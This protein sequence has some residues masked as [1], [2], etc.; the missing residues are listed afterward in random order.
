MRLLV[1]GAT[2]FVGRNVVR[3]A[4]DGGHQ[5]RALVRDPTRAASTFGDWPVE[6]VVG[7]LL[8]G[9]GLRPALE[10]IDV[11]V[12]SAATYSYRRVDSSVML[13]D[14]RVI[15][16]TLLSAAAEAG[17]AHV[18]DISSGIALRP[19]RSGSRAGITDAVSPNW[20]AA[21]PQWRDP[22]LRSKVE[23]DQVARRFAAAGL[24]VTSIHPSNVIGPGD[25]GPGT[26]GQALVTLLASPAMAVEA[27]SNWVDVRDLAG[28]IVA[29]A[30]RPP[31]GRYLLSGGYF[32]FREMA[33]VIDAVTGRRPRRLWTSAR[34]TR[35]GASTN[36]LFDGRIMP[37]MPPRTS[38]DYMLTVG[39]MDGS[40]GAEVL[41]RP[42]RPMAETISD[43]LRWWAEHGVVPRR[44]IGRLGA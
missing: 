31:G 33:A 30:A 5:V 44:L 11:L 3:A 29:I 10:G 18:L 4:L 8:T 21:D 27:R 41:G 39:P 1:A 2:G 16:E 12:Q 40:S 35:L 32:P 28:G 9:A 26:S 20:E 34:M 17:T 42:Y 22:Y 13:R 23:A 14:N 19:H 25:T 24:P 38:L 6:V 43:T 37:I 36:D 7:D 15:T